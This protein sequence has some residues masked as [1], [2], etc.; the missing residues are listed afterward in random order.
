MFND[1][2]NRG[3]P[4]RSQGE[5][6]IGRQSCLRERAHALEVAG[7]LHERLCAMCVVEIAS[8]GLGG[9]GCARA[10]TGI[11]DEQA[12]TRRG[13]KCLNSA[14]SR[15]STSGLDRV[16]ARSTTGGL[17][18]PRRDAPRRSLRRERLGT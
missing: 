7:Q 5:W 10:P 6:R 11:D 17:R 18:V 16:L 1:A 14:Q 2:G 8:K 12:R 15:I 4:C 3:I 9:I 13:D